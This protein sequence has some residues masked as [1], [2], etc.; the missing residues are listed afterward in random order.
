ML[1]DPEPADPRGP[2][3]DL[4]GGPSDTAW[5]RRVCD[6]CVGT[7]QPWGLWDKCEHRERSA[8]LSKR[9]KKYYEAF[10]LA[11]QL[12][13]AHGVEGVELVLYTFTPPGTI[14]QDYEFDGWAIGRPGHELYEPIW[15]PRDMQ[16]DWADHMTSMFAGLRRT[17][18]WEETGVTGGIW[19]YECKARQAGDHVCFHRQCKCYKHPR[20]GKPCCACDAGHEHCD[21][22]DHYRTVTRDEWHPHLHVVA[23]K[24]PGRP[25]KRS[26]K[27]LTAYT[28]EHGF[29]Y[30]DVDSRRSGNLQWAV[31][32]ATKY[33]A[34]QR[35][36]G[37]RTTGVFGDL[38][39]KIT[40]VESHRRMMRNLR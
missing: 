2:M 7:W 38:V 19:A 35:I 28:Q 3:Q 25:A 23:R 13:A 33:C 15:K 22:G 16:A 40:A 24:Q 14:R 9:R 1:D 29:G 5:R 6:D 4:R 32:Y 10:E 17:H 36:A 26:A 21:R 18:L 39:G 8:A 12:D 30:V 31:R 20:T 11:D 27:A 34:K 37:T